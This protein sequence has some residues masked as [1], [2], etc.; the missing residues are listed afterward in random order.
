MDYPYLPDFV[1]LNITEDTIK[2]VAQYYLSGGARLGGTDAHALQQWLLQFG[3]SSHNVWQ[4]TVKLVCGDAWYH[5]AAE[6]TLQV[7][8]SNAK[9]LCDINQL[10]A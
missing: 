10:C 8:G 7:A 2:V 1:N 5:L 6:A 9:E 4:A 3:S